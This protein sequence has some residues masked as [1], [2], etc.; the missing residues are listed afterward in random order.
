M[1][2]VFIKIMV[3][4]GTVLSSL[5]ASDVTV[6]RCVVMGAVSMKIM[7]FRSTVPCALVENNVKLWAVLAFGWGER[8]PCPGRRLRG[9]A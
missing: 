1:V 4:R 2:A 8:G 6:M 3:F 9:G 7:E 5:V